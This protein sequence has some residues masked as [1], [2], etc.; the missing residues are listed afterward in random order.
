MKD[1]IDL[2]QNKEPRDVGRKRSL[3]NSGKLKIKKK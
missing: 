1:R 3:S 2:V